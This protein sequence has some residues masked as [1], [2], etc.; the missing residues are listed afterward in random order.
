M[1]LRLR[2]LPLLFVCLAS[3]VFAGCVNVAGGGMAL[4]LVTFL[5][6]AFGMGVAACSDNVPVSNNTNNGRDVGEDVRSGD[7]DD[8]ADTGDS[9]PV[10]S[11]EDED[12]GVWEACC[13][14]GVVESCF[15]PA[16]MACNYGWF[17]TCDDGT[18]SSGLE[19][20]SDSDAGTSDVDDGD[21]VQDVDTDNDA[22]AADPDAEDPDAEAGS[23]ES[24]CKSGVV[25]SCFCPANMACNYGMYHDCGEGV[26]VLGGQVCPEDF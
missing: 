2:L 7:T 20:C 13:N 26:C 25:D 15:C 4:S 1:K 9:D 18:C 17:A 5:V 11:G 6:L 14:N 23:W 22:D 10:D 8:V 3:F 19:T 12:A 16:N 21:A 24:C